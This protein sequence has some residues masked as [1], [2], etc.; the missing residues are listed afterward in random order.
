[1]LSHQYI[2]N[3][4]TRLRARLKFLGQEFDQSLYGLRDFHVPIKLR[5][6]VNMYYASVICLM[7]A[8]LCVIICIFWVLGVAYNEFFFFLLNNIFFANRSA[9]RAVQRVEILLDHM[10]LR[11]Q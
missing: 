4:G 11:Q 10:V 1:M 6:N 2:N 3:K 9:T 7:C 5:L 8:I